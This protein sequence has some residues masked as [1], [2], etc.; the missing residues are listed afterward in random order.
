MLSSQF[1]RHLNRST[2]ARFQAM[3]S[4]YIQVQD[5]PNPL[6][7]KFLPGQ[8]ILDQ[9]RTYEYTSVAAARD[10]PLAR[11]LFR[12]D[13]VRSVFFG[14]DFITVTKKDE[15]TN[16]GLMRAEIMSTIA[17]FIESGKP[18]ISEGSVPEYSD[19]AIHEDDDDTVAMIKELLESRVRPMVQEDGGD[20]MYMGFEDGVVKLKM[21][22]SCTG[23]PSS[24]LTLKSGI[25][26]MLQ[27]YVPE[28]KE[29]VEVT[30]E[31]DDL[32]KRELEK[33]EKS[34]GI[35]D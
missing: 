32:A 11:E 1:L 13:G 33:F 22:G 20:I 4:L 29:V 18:V 10:S 26:N 35:V 8:A 17:N 5:T 6:S 16:W 31:S 14:E 12:V 24:S 27:F 34:R 3:R 25:Q 19:T 15:E 30:D 9:P 7:L 23:C 28:V 2:Q 21:K